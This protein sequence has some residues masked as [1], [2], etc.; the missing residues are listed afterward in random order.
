MEREDLRK[1]KVATIVNNFPTLSQT[2]V[3]LQIS[4]LIKHGH[5]VTICYQGK[6]NALDTQRHGVTL[7]SAE[8][9][10]LEAKNRNTTRHWPIKLGWQIA[11]SPVK[12]LKLVLRLATKGKIRWLPIVSRHL[13]LITKLQDK[14]I[15]HCQFANL[16]G[17][18]ILFKKLGLLN[19]KTKLACSIR[20]FDI[21]KANAVDTTDW[22]SLFEN[23]DAF[24]PVCNHFKE[25]LLKKGC[26]KPVIVIPSPVEIFL[27]DIET[28]KCKANSRVA[29]V[30][31]GR[32]VEK[33]GILTAL[34]ALKQL[35]KK[36]IDFHYIVIG[37]GP[38]R[39]KLQ[40]YIRENAIENEVCIAGP[41]N[42]YET[43]IQIAS[44]DLMLTPSETA[45]DGDSEG[46]PNVIKEAMLLEKPCISTRHAGIPE[47]IEHG[48]TG[49]LCREKSPSDL[50]KT[51]E[52][53]ISDKESWAR[54]ATK[55]RTL[56]QAEFSPEA[57]TRKLIRSYESL[58]DNSTS[59][60]D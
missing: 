59:I 47:I 10:K 32:L 57:T 29:I 30:S 56:A 11:K 40:A 58:V 8:F 45:S 28:K 43:L 27:S 31:V 3:T 2:F 18:I 19:S 1:M 22:K 6:L 12:S 39:E 9:L 14:D 33:K 50:A 24:Y 17:P 37:D 34:E 5:H 21:S 20:G 26:S 42:H 51:I 38:E 52:Y 13:S 46:I 44:A 36:G 53:A 55:A 35:K 60:E 23:I 49:Y 48:I 54:I 7:G 16:A 4:E 41:M 25:L 15:I